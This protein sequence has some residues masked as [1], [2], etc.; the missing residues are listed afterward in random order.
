MFASIRCIPSQY[1][2]TKWDVTKEKE[3]LLNMS[4]ISSINVDDNSICMTNGNAYTN[5]HPDDV[6]KIVHYFKV[7]EGVM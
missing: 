2:V 1:P 7:N 6:S 4:Y 3:V 5:I